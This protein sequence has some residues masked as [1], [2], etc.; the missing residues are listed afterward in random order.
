MLHSYFPLSFMDVLLMMRVQS[1]ADI[2]GLKL[3]Y[4]AVI[5]VFVSTVLYM[6]P[7]LLSPVYVDNPVSF[8]RAERQGI[9][10]KDGHV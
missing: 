1:S 8:I 5:D 9:H 3:Q 2:L 7:Q 10:S 6:Q 4:L